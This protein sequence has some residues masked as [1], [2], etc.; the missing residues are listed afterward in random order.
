MKKLFIVAIAALGFAFSAQ[1]QEGFGAGVNLGLPMGD[2]DDFYGFN[3]GVDVQYLGAVSE[4]FYAGGTIGY[5][6][7]FG[8]TYDAAPGI[9]IEQEDIQFLPIAAVAKFMITEDFSVGTDLGYALGL[10][11]DV[12]GGFYYRPKLGYRIADSIELNLSYAGI[13]LED[14]I[15]ASTFNI[16][17]MFQL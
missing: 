6:H 16:G 15:N 11:E 3:A 10:K 2:L 7:Y 8:K 4:T 1:A 17:F 13:S 5:S 9:E 14:D 12:D